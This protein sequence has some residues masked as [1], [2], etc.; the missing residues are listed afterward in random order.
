MKKVWISLFVVSIIIAGCSKDVVQQEEEPVIEDIE[1]VEKEE[2]Q[3]EE[4]EEQVEEETSDVSQSKTDLNTKDE[5]KEQD[6]TAEQEKDVDKSNTELTEE[7]AIRLVKIEL[8]VEHDDFIH[9]VVDHEKDGM[10]VVQVYEV[11]DNGVGHTATLG[12]YTVDK[13]SGEIKSMI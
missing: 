3:K 6:K 8:G 11:V 4:I 7:D 1:Q 12:W 5:Q 10:Y 2:E 9:V 13:K